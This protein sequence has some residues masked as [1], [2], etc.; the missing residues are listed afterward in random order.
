M[1]QYSG[2]RLLTR[3]LVALVFSLAFFVAQVVA[4]H[5]SSVLSA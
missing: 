4:A 5:R 3:K 2:L 1:T